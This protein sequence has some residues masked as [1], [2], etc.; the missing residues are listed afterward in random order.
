MDACLCS[1]ARRR[2][3]A[4]DSV[5][6]QGPDPDDG[7]VSWL[8]VTASGQRLLDR[9]REVALNDFDAALTGWSREDRRTLAELLRRLQRALLEAEVDEAG[10]SKPR[11]AARVQA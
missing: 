9:A 5:D 8:R 4:R 10:W 6:S 3:Q 7:R 2:E 11:T 1:I